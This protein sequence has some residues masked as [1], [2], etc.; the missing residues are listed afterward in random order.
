[1]VV[2]LKGC[3]PEGWDRHHDHEGCLIYMKHHTTASF[4]YVVVTVGKLGIH[5]K[6]WLNLS[7]TRKI[8]FIVPYALGVVPI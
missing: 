3:R 4:V 1:M 2:D 6:S 5:Q 7:W 8:I